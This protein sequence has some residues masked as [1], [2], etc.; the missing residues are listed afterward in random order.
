MLWDARSTT[1]TLDL[2]ARIRR[3]ADHSHGTLGPSRVISSVPTVDRCQ[4]KLWTNRRLDMRGTGMR[5]LCFLGA[6]VRLHMMPRTRAPGCKEEAEVAD[7]EKGGCDGGNA[8]KD[9]AGGVMKQHGSR[10][11]RVLAAWAEKPKR[12]DVSDRDGRDE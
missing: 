11:Q 7:R 3:R 8:V 6:A 4:Y 5:G 10:Q 9:E 1:S 2:S 12:G